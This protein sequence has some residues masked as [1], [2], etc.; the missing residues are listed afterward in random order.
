MTTDIA[1]RLGNTLMGAF[2]QPIPAGRATAAGRA[3]SVW[4]KLGRAVFTAPAR[5]VAHLQRRQAE[6]DAL[7]R[8]A[9]TEGKELGLGRSEI[10]RAVL[11]TGRAD[12]LFPSYFVNAQRR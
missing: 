12:M 5:F 2:V 6:R 10:E 1:T 4:Q 9:M 3:P 11:L 8:Y 7:I